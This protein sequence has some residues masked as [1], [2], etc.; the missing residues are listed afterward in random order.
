M[1]KTNKNSNSR[2]FKI[3][4]PKKKQIMIAAGH[5]GIVRVCLECHEIVILC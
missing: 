1:I 4:I 5:T 3:L 2:K